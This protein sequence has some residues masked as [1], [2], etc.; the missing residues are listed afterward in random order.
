[1]FCRVKSGF[2]ITY[3]YSPFTANFVWIARS[4]AEIRLFLYRFDGYIAFMKRQFLLAKYNYTLIAMFPRTRPYTNRALACTCDCKG[5]CSRASS[6]RER[7]LSR[8]GWISKHSQKDVYSSGKALGSTLTCS[9]WLWLMTASS[10]SG[11]TLSL[12]YK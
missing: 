1:M 6:W 11:T 9:Y 5:R 4:V 3:I 7:A 10:S 12:N 2:R 8:T